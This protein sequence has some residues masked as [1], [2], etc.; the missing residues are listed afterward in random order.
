MT[1]VHHP[2]FHWHHPTRAEVLAFIARWALA[3]LVI[4]LIHGALV[5]IGLYWQRDQEG[6]LPAAAMVIELA[7][8]AVSSPSETPDIAPGPPMV[9]APE[10][11]PD[12]PETPDD[13]PP[14]PEPQVMEKVEEV[15]ELPPPPPMAEVMLP[16][17]KPV[18]EVKEKPKPQEKP[19]PPKKKASRKPA[20]PTTTAA[21]K[22][23]APV[24]TTAAA[25]AIG[26]SSAS[27][28]AQATWRGQLMAHLNRYKRYPADANG[29]KGMARLRFTIDRSGRVVSASL[30][31]SAGSAV[32]D[33]E[34]LALI[35]RASP[36]PAPP[37]EIGGSTISL[38]VPVN[39]N[40]R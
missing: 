3:A 18:E 12:A 5:Y 27:S 8:L 22:T 10:P 9:K 13:S 37:P 7:D 34:V 40:P 14:P 30:A 33:R 6:D 25:P 15:F 29:D 32:L 19:E 1:S 39:F 16:Q 24:A 17:Q 38:T 21:P 36:V 31:G 4:F 28:A 35:H 11:V 2:H 26:A 20:A 23:D